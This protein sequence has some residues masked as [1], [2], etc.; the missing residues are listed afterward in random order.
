MK[1]I[2]AII[3]PEKLSAVLEALMHASI[4]GLSI[5]RIQGHGGE[6]ET[7]ETY[8]GTTVKMSLHDKIRIEIGLQVGEIAIVL[9]FLLERVWFE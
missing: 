8:R 6:T 3:R 1:L 4:R 5:T 7:V 9:F 2:V